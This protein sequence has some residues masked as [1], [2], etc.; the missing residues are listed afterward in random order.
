[1]DYIPLFD[2]YYEK[3]K[4][5]GCFKILCS[6]FVT[7]D[8]GTGIV[9]T[10]PAYGEDD[11]KVALSY[12]IINPNDP[13]ISIDDNG[14]FLPEVSDFQG[15]YIKDADPDIIANLKARQRIIK[16]G[17]IVHS[18]PYCWRSNTPLVYKAVATWFIKV[19]SIKQDLV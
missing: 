17:T 16:Q 13:C 2:Y 10:S 9:H 3:M 11:Y 18:Y 8:T 14:F 4:P 12:S 6:K 19:S 15:R 7:S 5:R 1:M